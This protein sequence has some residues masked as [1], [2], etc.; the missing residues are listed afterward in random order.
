[1]SEIIVEPTDA[2]GYAKALAKI[3]LPKH[4]LNAPFY[5]KWQ[6]LSGKNVVYYLITENKKPIGCGLAV[7]L[8]LPRGYYYYYSPYGPLTQ[9]WP[10]DTTK[11][12]ENFFRGF[13][14][15]KL[16]FVRLDGDNFPRTQLKTATEATAA[17][18]ALQPR[19]EW[20]LDISKSNEEL[21]AGMHKK[22]RYHIKLSERGG[23]SF[24]VETN[25]DDKLERFYELM[26]TTAARD[27]FHILPKSDYAAAFKACG[28]NAFLGYAEINGKPVAGAFCV[29]YD[30][31]THYV[32]GCSSNEFRQ[33]G[34]GYYLH[35]NLILH[36]KDKGQK[37]YN[38]GGISGG[39][40]GAQLAGV[41]Q[42]KQKF[43]GFAQTHGLPVD[44]PLNLLGYKLFSLY[45][46]LR[47]H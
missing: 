46:H 25:L 29:S 3:K 38:F 18:A 22:A 36:A 23:A 7:A 15:K 4:F 42:F 6:D 33:L 1:M 11:A 40:K 27:N 43:G 5:G 17:T 21:L 35:W 30:N 8:K 14:D 34:I 31:V 19:T 37:I 44:I 2:S 45:K 26:K 12:I 10:V 24:R 20:L 32:Y 47:R 9:D 13:N 39:V 41:T 28:E 16:L